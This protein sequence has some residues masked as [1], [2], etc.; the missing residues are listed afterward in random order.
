MSGNPGC[1]T[2]LPSINDLRVSRARTAVLAG[3]QASVGPLASGL[4]ALLKWVL[5]DTSGPPSNCGYL[6]EAV[7]EQEERTF[8]CPMLVFSP[9]LVLFRCRVKMR[10]VSVQSRAWILCPADTQP[11][12]SIL[13]SL[14][15]VDLR[16]K[17][18]TWYEGRDG[19]AESQPRAT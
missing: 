8:L 13:G 4:P 16:G 14:D 10:V 15:L 9:L 7:V 3:L 17:Q 12:D 6:L 11:K 18:N 2:W 19:E 1:R 5:V